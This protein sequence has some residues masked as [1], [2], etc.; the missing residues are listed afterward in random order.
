MS[1][2]PL[3]FTNLTSGCVCYVDQWFFSR[4]PFPDIFWL[5]TKQVSLPHAVSLRAPL[6]HWLCVDGCRPSKCLFARLCAHI[7]DLTHLQ[8]LLRSQVC[9]QPISL[10]HY[11]LSTQLTT[12]HGRAGCSLDLS[13]VISS[14]WHLWSG[15]DRIWI[16]YRHCYI[17]EDVQC[18]PTAQPPSPLKPN[19]ICSL[20]EACSFSY[21]M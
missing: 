8:W 1:D 10:S 2:S 5:D 19:E 13:T 17:I 18:S 7:C 15:V 16:S 21:M 4:C 6:P 12:G 14:A 9:S 3:T 11:L 20:I